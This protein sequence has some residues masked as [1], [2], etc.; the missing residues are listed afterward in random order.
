MPEQSCPRPRTTR[1]LYVELAGAHAHI[2][3]LM[4]ELS[5]ERELVQRLR[6]VLALADL[7]SPAIKRYMPRRRP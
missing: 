4:R 5:A 6:T 3:E 7:A 2:A 1:Q